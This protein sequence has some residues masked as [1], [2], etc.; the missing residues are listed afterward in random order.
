MSRARTLAFTSLAAISSLT[1]ACGITSIGDP[2]PGDPTPSV[3]PFVSVATRDPTLGT[4]R[5]PLLP[6]PS[7]PAPQLGPEPRV[8]VDER[9]R[10]GQLS[11]RPSL[12]VA[13]DGRPHLALTKRGV[14]RYGVSYYTRDPHE[15]WQETPDVAGGDVQPLMD[16]DATG[17]PRLYALDPATNTTNLW[18]LGPDRRVL[19]SF[20]YTQI[21]Q[22]LRDGS[23][24]VIGLLGQFGGNNYLS[25][26]EGDD[27]RR[28]YFQTRGVHA[29]SPPGVYTSEGTFAVLSGLAF[30]H[31][32]GR[33]EWLAS[34]ETREPPPVGPAAASDGTL[35]VLRNEKGSWDFGNRV[36]LQRRSGTSWRAPTVLV[37]DAPPPPVTSCPVAVGEPC[38][39]EIEQHAGVGLVVA[40]E[41]AIPLLVR[42][43]RTAEYFRQCLQTDP[44]FI[45]CGMPPCI[46]EGGPAGA[47]IDN[48]GRGAVTKVA[49]LVDGVEAKLAVPLEQGQSLEVAA[50][51]EGTLHIVATRQVQGLE[52]E[53]RYLVIEPPRSR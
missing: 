26:P 18:S 25:R 44:N 16:I 45:G 6:A 51:P 42:S 20:Q 23:G 12:R 1:L 36:L 13:P 40:G 5:P 9:L 30:T 31:F 34:G 15:G 21:Y 17:A 27:W 41:R 29:Y 47:W 50:S 33:T 8:V 4:L 32:G 14:T 37:A 39:F 46:D 28:D 49:L 53:M 3:D 2:S 24:D 35:F 19:D 7:D 38:R 10:V 11:K 43:T 22:V 52:Y 48:A